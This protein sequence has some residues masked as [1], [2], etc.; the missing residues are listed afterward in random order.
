MLLV[1]TMVG[2]NSTDKLV[3]DAMQVFCCAAHCFKPCI[4]CMF[5]THSQAVAAHIKAGPLAMCGTCLDNK[6]CDVIALKLFVPPPPT[7]Q[8]FA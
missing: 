7:L 3:D 8:V 2:C 5:C 4:T 6:T 1:Y